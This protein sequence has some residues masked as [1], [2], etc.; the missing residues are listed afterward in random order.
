MERRNSKNG[1]AGI[2]VKVLEEKVMGK[3][4]AELKER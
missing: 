1:M 2:G 4:S 3:K